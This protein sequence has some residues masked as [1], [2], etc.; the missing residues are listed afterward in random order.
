[1]LL[2]QLRRTTNQARYRLI[3]SY[4]VEKMLTGINT[5]LEYADPEHLCDECFA[6]SWRRS[7]GDEDRGMVISS[8]QSTTGVLTRPQR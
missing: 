5:P 4:S 6:R 2:K 7:C 3:F 1:M 8:R